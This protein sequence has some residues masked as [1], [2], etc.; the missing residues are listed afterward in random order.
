[1]YIEI[2]EKDGGV[3]QCGNEPLDLPEKCKKVSAN[4]K[5]S[6]RANF[7]VPLNSQKSRKWGGAKPILWV[8]SVLL[9]VFT[10]NSSGRWAS[11]LWEVKVHLSYYPY[12][13]SK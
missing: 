13:G 9:Q 3:V 2:A 12:K 8:Q 11:N 4:S 10:F 1:M 5:G 7:H 6:A